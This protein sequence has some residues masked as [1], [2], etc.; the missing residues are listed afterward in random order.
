MRKKQGPNEKSGTSRRRN[1]ESTIRSIT[2]RAK[3]RRR[4]REREREMRE[5][6]K[7]EKKERKET[8]HES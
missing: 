8:P 2:L 7:R 4:E 6:K 1:G 3:K 5:K